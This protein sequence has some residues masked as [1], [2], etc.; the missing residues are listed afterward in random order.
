MTGNARSWLLAGVGLLVA[1]GAVGA[2]GPAGVLAPMKFNEV[3]EVAPGVFFRYSSISATDPKVP[4]GGCN[5]IWVVFA[6]YV[7]VFDANFPKEAGDVIAAVRKTTAKPIRYVLDSH[8]HGDHAYGNDVFA[9]AG[10]SVVAQAHCARLL[11][12]NGPK[13]FAAAGSGKTGRPD[14]RDGKLKVPDLVFDDRLVL[15]DGTQRAEFYFF[16]H[17]HTAGDAF[18]YLPRHKVL[19][20]GDACVNGAY[21]FMGHSDSASWIRVLE[22]AQ[23][24]DVKL[25]CPG[26]GPL[27]GK[28][29]LGKQKRYFVELRQHVR[30]GID[31]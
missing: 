22:Q 29:L 18:L 31:A 13:E 17:A 8:H 20:T 12:V 21:N 24:L 7:V 9:K 1:G 14:V 27:A 19:C 25:V 16:G 6:D 3:R 10:A 26:H 11:R 30:K 28:E 5:N 15:D 23:Q 2:G 4:F